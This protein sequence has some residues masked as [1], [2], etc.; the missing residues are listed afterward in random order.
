M[1][2]QFFNPVNYLQSKTFREFDSIYTVKQFGYKDTQH[3][4]E[5][6]TLHNKLHRINVPVLCL[7]AADDPFQ[8]LEGS[9][10][11]YVI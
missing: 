2:H 11:K 9:C 1:N 3:F 4:Y 5:E 8:P 7:S 10:L 6:A